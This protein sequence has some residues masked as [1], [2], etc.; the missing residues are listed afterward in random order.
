VADRR[1]AAYN[2]ID[3]SVSYPELYMP[4]PDT[5][6]WLVLVLVCI[7]QFMVVLDATIVNVA[8]PSIQ[9]DLDFSQGSLQWVINGYTL[10]FGGF[11][12]LGGRASDLFG[13]KRVFL[14][15]IVI[16]SA[17]SLLN[18][19]AQ[20]GNML[21]AARAL[22]GLGAALV[23]PAA[24]S[25][26][27]TTFAEGEDRAKALGVWSAIAAGG[28]AFGLLLGGVLTDLFSWEWI[29]FVNVPIGVAAF[30]LSTRYVPESVAP[31]RPDSV[32]L[33][34][35]IS[36]TAGLMVLVYAIVKA[37]DYGWG[38]ARTLALGAVAIGLLV[39][40]VF[41]ERRSSAPLIRLDIFRSRNI[42]GANAIMVLVAG[43]MFAF[44]FLSSLYVQQVLGYSPLQAGLA[45]LPFTLGII[46][47][48]GA[49]Q[50]LGRRIPIHY[51][52]I[53]GIA[54]AGIGLLIMAQAGPDGT[55]LGNLLPA[56]I[57]M[58]IGMG[59]TFLPLTLVATTGVSASDAG[60]ASGLFNTSQQ[61]GGALGLAILSTIAADRTTNILSDLGRAVGAPERVSALVEGFQVAYYGGIALMFVGAIVLLA[62]L[63]TG[64]V[65]EVDPDAQ[66]VAVG[67]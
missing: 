13:R 56:I 4:Q 63:R 3:R 57:P 47:G 48:A 22:Q 12:L 35:A 6:R 27:T 19:L 7:A 11:L 16:F 44:F 41:I 18:G 29:F 9:A 8:L 17:A 62:V 34:G 61:V 36:V 32:D 65:A 54:L 52:A 10:V 46:V 1:E 45:F 26:I 24:L 67:A 64:D 38:S 28:A 59:M 60:L 39:A 50:A 14:I 2:R 5:N 23:S 49:S 51:V 15:G 55:Y 43:G 37:E 30:L 20:S 42:S 66:P 25:I 58:S 40:F 21:I 31:E 33:P 53:V